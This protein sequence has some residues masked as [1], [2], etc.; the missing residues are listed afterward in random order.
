VTVVEAGR[1]HKAAESLRSAAIS[2]PIWHG[3]GV[4]DDRTARLI[5]RP[6]D[7]D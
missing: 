1:M 5:V 2:L 7:M 3:V 4:D 6:V